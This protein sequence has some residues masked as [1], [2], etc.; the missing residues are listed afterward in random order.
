MPEDDAKAA[1]AA[2]RIAELEAE[3]HRCSATLA[4]LKGVPDSGGHAYFANRIEELVAEIEALKA[5]AEKP[6][7]KRDSEPA[8]AVL[9]GIGL[10]FAVYGLL[11]RAWTALLIG[12]ALIGVSQLMKPKGTDT[13]TKGS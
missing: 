3:L 2:K 10:T 12:A 1:L 7:P 11:Q 9:L 6:K 8:H 5:P 4:N 13:E